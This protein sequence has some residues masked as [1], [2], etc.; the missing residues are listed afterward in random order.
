MEGSK[1]M[2]HVVNL[3]DFLENNHTGKVMRQPARGDLT[4]IRYTPAG[5]ARLLFVGGAC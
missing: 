5:D 2:Y 4:G 1:A 3:A